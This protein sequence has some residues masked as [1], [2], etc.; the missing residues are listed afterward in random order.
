MVNNYAVFHNGDID[1]LKIMNHNVQ[2]NRKKILFIKDSFANAFILLFALQ[3]YEIHE[4]D[5]RFP[6]APLIEDYIAD[7]KPD[8]VIVFID[9]ESLEKNIEKRQW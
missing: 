2:N 1:N 3:T 8:I 9:V 6:T 4:L 5:L 7:E